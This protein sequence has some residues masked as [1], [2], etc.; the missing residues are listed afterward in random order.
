MDPSSVSFTPQSEIWQLSNTLRNV[1]EVQQDHADRLLRLERRNDEEARV[2]SV[3]GP[4]S[5]FPGA[6][7]TPS[8]GPT[9]HQST[10]DFA[11][12]DDDQS[13]NMMRSLQLDADDEPRRVGATSRANSVRFDDSANQA[14]LAHNPRPSLDFNSRTSSLQ[15]L[16]GIPMFERS[17]SHKSDGRHSS[18]G[19]STSGRANSLG[20]DTSHSLSETASQPPGLAPGLFI[21]GSVPSIIRCWLNTNFK[22]E[23]VLYAAIC[24]GSYKSFIDSRLISELGLEEQVGQ[25]INGDEK[26]KLS[27]YLPEAVPTS[28]S[29]RHGASPQLPSFTVDFAITDQD[30]QISSKA[31]RCFIGS[32]ALR[33]HNA[34]ILMST[35]SMTIFD[36][37][38]SKW[39]TPLVRPENDAAFKTLATGSMLPGQRKRRGDLREPRSAS[40]HRLER[41]GATNGAS[42]TRPVI[43][44]SAATLEPASAS[45]ETPSSDL[46]TTI[47]PGTKAAAGSSATDEQ[48]HTLRDVGHDRKPSLSLSISRTD[49]REPSDSATAGSRSAASPA[50]WNNWRKDANPPAAQNDWSNTSR[51]TSSTYSRPTREGGIKVLK[52]TRQMS[53]SSVGPQGANSPSFS[54]QSRFFDDGKRRTGPGSD[55]GD[56]TGQP[57]KVSAESSKPMLG[58]ENATPVAQPA[59]R[60]ANP[61]GGASAFG[62]LHSSSGK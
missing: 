53:R 9:R 52:P 49:A 27:V 2:K 13:S 56:S 47:G 18:T 41:S 6:L 15:G 23:S 24:T 28:S 32:D 60:S 16:G 1:Q 3:W 17:S 21:L 39:S 34:D 48:K 11:S 30:Q 62:W 8:Q 45:A 55:S 26:I 10:L 4:T 59:K 51:S 36:D 33:A 5:P 61:V 12:F 54:G 46:D 44:T 57:Q 19:H 35:N 22:S 43:E 38:R 31:I 25:D 29:S 20:L 37:E 42:T 7:S 58:K 50:I 40:M 14:Q